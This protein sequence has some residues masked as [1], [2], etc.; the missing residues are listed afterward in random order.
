MILCREDLLHILSTVAVRSDVMVYKDRNRVLVDK[1][2]RHNRVIIFLISIIGASMT[3]FFI[4]QSLDLFLKSSARSTVRDNE[5]YIGML[6]FACVFAIMTAMMI[7]LLISPRYM[8]KLLNI[9]APELCEN[10]GYDLRGS[11]EN[12]EPR[13]PE[14]GQLLSKD[15]IEELNLFTQQGKRQNKEAE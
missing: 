7:W 9:D 4:Y 12:I 10:C 15:K 2:T 14:C 8:R 3:C 6:F 11:L 1:D 13:C 5:F